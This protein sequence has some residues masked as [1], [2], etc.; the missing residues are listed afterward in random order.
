MAVPENAQTIWNY[1]TSHGF[2]SNAAAGIEG[3]IE[4][5]S[6]GSPTAGVWPSNYGLIQWTPASSYFNSPPSLQQQLAGILSYVNANGSVG[7]VNAHAASP[8]DAALY[9]SNTYERP[10]P[11]VANNANRENSAAQTAQ[12]AQS[13]SWPQSS[14]SGGGG[15]GGSGSPASSGSTCAGITLFGHCLGVS[16]PNFAGDIQDWLERGAL[17]VFGAI[18]VII[19][20][21]KLVDAK[22]PIS[23]TNMIPGGTGGGSGTGNSTAANGEASG[24]AAGSGIEEAAEVAAA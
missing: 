6:G 10:D 20:V 17:I 22:A 11:A 12:A 23:I 9:F 18:F 16:V 4:Q 7:D 5:E 2:S 15:S 19:G 1:L 13:N 14:G 24:E 3:N 8:Q 21:I